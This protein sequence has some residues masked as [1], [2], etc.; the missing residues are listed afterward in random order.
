ME[1]GAASYGVVNFTCDRR[2]R[3]SITNK[4]AHSD[5]FLLQTLLHD[6]LRQFETYNSRNTSLSHGAGKL[7]RVTT[8]P[9]HLL[10]RL[11]F[12]T[13]V[14]ITIV[15]PEL[16]L[17][18]NDISQRQ[19]AYQ[20]M[21]EHKQNNLAPVGSIYTQTSDKPVKQSEHI[22]SSYDSYPIQRYEKN[23][24]PGVLKSIWTGLAGG[25]NG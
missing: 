2:V 20:T 12:T 14:Q 23:K 7:K 19:H 8:A 17:E 4:P 15:N 9:A 22:E 13:P 6:I 3:I 10:H 21:R 5:V 24:T 16:Q 25:R 1:H 11:G 18:R